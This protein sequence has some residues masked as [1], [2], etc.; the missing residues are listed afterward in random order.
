M[1]SVCGALATEVLGNG[2]RQELHPP[3]RLRTDDQ[4]VQLV[5]KKQE[6]VRDF[7]KAKVAEVA[8]GNLY[9][10]KGMLKRLQLEGERDLSANA[11]V[12]QG[13]M[14]GFGEGNG[15]GEEDAQKRRRPEAAR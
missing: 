1:K 10:F 12:A 8:V 7:V 11:S 3:A 6:R 4:V 5:K 13:G 2:W 9:A 15:D 14:G